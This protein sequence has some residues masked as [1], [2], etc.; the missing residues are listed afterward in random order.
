MLIL[1]G[2]LQYIILI[3]LFAFFLP[4]V[5]STDVPPPVAPPDL[6]Y[7]TVVACA[8]VYVLPL[9]IVVGDYG[10]QLNRE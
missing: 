4:L 6:C 1:R 7:K 8:V 9:L 2:I 10:N 5:M 3:F